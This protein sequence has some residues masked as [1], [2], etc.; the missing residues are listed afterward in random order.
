MK[1]QNTILID[2][3]KNDY[4]DEILDIPEGIITIGNYAC[5]NLKTKKIVVPEGVSVIEDYAF[6]QSEDVEEIVLPKSLSTIKERAFSS[7]KNFKKIT[8]PKNLTF[9]GNS[10]F[11]GC[12]NLEEI[13][14]PK[15]V[16]KINYRAFANCKKLKKIIIEDGVE[17]IDWAAFT[18]CQSLE[19]INLPNSIKIINKQAFMNCKN[20]RKITLPECLTS[21]SDKLFSGCEKLDII[22]NKNIKTLGE[23]TFENCKN[24]KEYPK[25]I[26]SFGTGC[27]KGCR[28]LRK[29][30]LGEEIHNLPD[31]SFMECI[32]LNQIT[33]KNNQP[34]SIGKKCFKDCK[35]LKEIPS[36]VT[37]YNDFAFENC[38]SFTSINIIN[39]H[40]PIGCFR[41]CK[42]LTTINHQDM[43]RSIDSFSFSG[44]SKLTE[45]DFEN[46]NID[47]PAEAFSNCK[48][49][50]KIKLNPWINRIGT[51]AFFNCTSLT[52]MKIPIGVTYIGKEAFSG[53]SSMEEIT[54]P[55]ELDT[56]GN[57]AFY[58]MDSLKT[59]NVDK[60]NKN[61]TTHDHKILIHLF[62]EAV[63]LYAT[64]NEDKHYSLK[65]YNLEILENGSECIR[66]IRR[67]A[68]HAFSNA[69][70]LE[71]LTICGC[72]RSIEFNTF[73][74]CEKLKKLNIEAISFCSCPIIHVEENGMMIFKEDKRK[75][76]DIP[77]EEVTF[78][79]NL[80]SISNNALDC[81]KKVKKLNLE[82]SNSY[83]ISMRAFNDCTE[84]KEV[85]IPECVHTIEQEAFPRTTKL[86]FK[87]GLVLD[88][89]DRLDSVNQYRL[90]YKL[91]T[92]EDGAYHIDQNGTI[93]TITRDYIDKICS[94]S[95]LIR[96]NPVLFLD[97]MND[98]ITHDLVV[99]ELLNGI[100]IKNISLESRELL[101][102][103]LDK[104]DS[105]YLKVLKDSGI[106]DY[107]DSA[108]KK[109]LERNSFTKV[110]DYINFIKQEKIE[111][112]ILCHRYLLAYYDIEQLK[113]LFN[114]NRQLLTQTLHKLLEN[115]DD[116]NH[117]II[118]DIL[119]NNQL[120]KFI[121]YIKENNIKD[122]FLI[123]KAFISIVDNPLADQ[124][125]KSY[126]A[127]TK[128]LLKESKVLENDNTLE[129]NMN[130]LLTLLYISGAL[131]N[132]PIIK[133]K[134]TTLITEKIFAEK[135]DNG[136]VNTT[137]IVGDDIHRVFN[138]VEV[139]DEFD[140]EFSLFFLEN[141]KE[142]IEQ[143]K[144][145][146][147][148]IQRIYINF[149][150]I[151]KTCTSNKGS[152]RKLKVTMRKCLD[153]LLTVKFDHIE[154]NREL[155]ALIGQWYDKNEDW[156]DALRVYKESLK[157]PRNI[158][159]KVEFDQENHP[160]YDN[161]PELDLKEEINENYSYEWLPKQAYENLILGKYC[162][163]CA[164]I[165]GAGQGIMRASMILDNCQNLVIRNG[166]G[167]II[168]KA[169]L[170]INKVDGY[171]VF[172]NVEGSL[173]Y[174]SEQEKERIYQAFMRGAEAFL[175]TYN[176]NHPNHP[177]SNISIG[178][179][180]NKILDYLD[181]E[182]HPIVEIQKSLNFGSYAL[183]PY[184]GY[185]GDWG[186][187]QRL[188][189]KTIG[190]RK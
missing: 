161:N 91:Y 127:N 32:H 178:A 42:N 119:T 185:N 118:K 134:A 8:L 146:S 53:C 15:G 128:R 86:K 6:Y 147:G 143:E 73:E 138:F 188:V 173:S 3:N 59:I 190:E 35:N 70:N 74:G 11:C 14:I 21:L 152:Q 30:E 31:E 9:I 50:K 140:Q 2:I 20:L 181:D 16:K 19:E 56:I 130:D 18:D 107:E 103:S 155:A 149:R 116:K 151:S 104:E 4:T 162:S 160:I 29:I 132:D 93:T 113:E 171:G 170:Y 111:D 135:L 122:S 187:K 120:K 27:F 51:R 158:F 169:T 71:E 36:F 167:E 85:E 139:R 142:L 112:P 168:A 61:Y 90:P 124:F 23:Y 105:I 66:P 67:L 43:I 95:K 184:H 96:D 144:S 99:N 44:C 114:R 24:L 5:H 63:I 49:L 55:R 38:E 60:E 150:D 166:F 54:I 126:D 102:N 75:K 72:T 25:H 153:Y 180:R 154:E 28:S 83:S 17:E 69:K 52:D 115:I 176:E 92:L 84:L 39:R 64:G 183:E 37:E 94:N 47:I 68:P 110:I 157:A 79:G 109:I 156:L 136:T 137:R 46:V 12:E 125:F 1:I 148:I 145:V 177:L 81:F 117:S 106:L 174:S 88:N 186:V 133:Q 97:Y 175:N 163:C 179:N 108:T 189:V 165:R 159:T 131:S 87:N 101:L 34:I 57:D 33:S 22:L 48:S 141:F 65:D 121:Q 82:D 41:G 100:L 26:T 58:K 77:F 172:N 89:L 78:T 123:N 13:T 182:N 164:H 40:I 98:L 76:I 62:Q 129:V 80:V 7:C 10:A 45:V